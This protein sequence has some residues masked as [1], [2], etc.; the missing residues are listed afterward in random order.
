MHK[1]KYCPYCGRKLAGANEQ[2][3]HSVSE[4][5]CYFCEMP[6]YKFGKK[7]GEKPKSKNH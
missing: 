4:L 2:E 1:S 3:D 5:F 7:A 6:L